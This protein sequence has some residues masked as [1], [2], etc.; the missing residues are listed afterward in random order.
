MEKLQELRSSAVE[1]AEIAK[2]NT[3]RHLDKAKVKF[4]QMCQSE[5][6]ADLEEESQVSS[7]TSSSRLEEFT[8]AYCPKLTFQQVGSF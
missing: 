5:E 2:K 8:D 7:E 6:E 3:A 1:M 4:K